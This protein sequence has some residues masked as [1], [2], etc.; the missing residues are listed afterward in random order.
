[1]LDADRG[2]L[3]VGQPAALGPRG[4]LGPSQRA[5]LL[6]E[7]KLAGAVSSGVEPHLVGGIG[8]VIVIG[9]RQS[10]DQKVGLSRAWADR[11]KV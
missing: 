5:V 4:Q 6:H 10:L 11:G 3:L 1:M 7:R 2:G 8:A 9:V